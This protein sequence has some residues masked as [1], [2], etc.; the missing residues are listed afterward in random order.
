[1][2]RHT[3]VVVVDGLRN[4]EAFEDPAHQHT[5]RMW[6]DLRPQ[7]TLYSDFCN[8]FVT[9]YTAPGHLA[10]LTGQWQVQINLVAEGIRDVRGDEPTIRIGASGAKPT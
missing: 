10:I 7:G 3:C 5:P 8:D 6:N 2:R 4:L 9:T 1:M